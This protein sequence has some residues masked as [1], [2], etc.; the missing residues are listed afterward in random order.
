M[1][2]LAPA[3][4]MALALSSSA[5]QAAC[6][7]A[8]LFPSLKQQAP[9]LIADVVRDAE[10]MPYG[11]GRL[12]RV[13]KAGV[14]PSH[15]FG[16]VHLADPR[17]ALGARAQ[18]ALRQARVVALE[19]EAADRFAHPETWG[20]GGRGLLRA[21]LAASEER[22][23]RLLPP[24]AVARLEAILPTYRLPASAARSFKPAVLAFLLSAPPC[25]M[26]GGATDLFLDAAIAREARA[27]G[28]PVVGLE[29]VTEQLD[30]VA[31]L[32]LAV[33]RDLL[34]VAMA[35]HSHGEDLVETAL[36]LYEAGEL[37]LLLSWMR[38]PRP[39]P[40]MTAD[41]PAAFLE[42]MLDRRNRVM[43]ERALPLLAEGRAFIAVGAAHLPGEAGLARL[44][45][46]S[47]YHVE[48]IE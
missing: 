33:Q 34:V 44:I 35:L 8:D 43:H 3:L 42:T 7:G 22:A 29:T 37:G 11:R 41:L 20:V 1:I 27:L 9:A 46:Q 36:R 47:G 28:I 45:A 25:L 18:E 23:E 32:P 39:V 14:A 5:A 30:A 26:K 13:T 12:F 4:A 15:L 6:R 38:H 24:D 21:L 2:R 10:H 31:G 48:A 19:L 17:A 16:T 40:G